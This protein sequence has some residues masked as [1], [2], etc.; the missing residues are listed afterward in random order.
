M[1]Q[2]QRAALILCEVLD[3]SAAVLQADAAIEVI[4]SRTWYSGVWACVPFLAAEAVFSPGDWRLLPTMANGQ[5]AA[6]AYLR[7][8]DQTRRANGLALL[9][10]E[11]RGIARITVFADPELVVKAGFPLRLLNTNATQAIC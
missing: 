11:P 4:P 2:R 3:W 8:T 10:C 7:D 5:P 9:T 6:V 1:P